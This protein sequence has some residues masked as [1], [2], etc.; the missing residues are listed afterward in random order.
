VEGYA[1][2]VVHG[3]LIATLLLD[4][5]HREL[6]LAQVKAFNFKALKP[7][8]DTAPFQVCGRRDGQQ[9][10]LWAVTPEGELAMEAQAQIA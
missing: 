7:L 1:G 10:F 5:L 3:P 9:V 4:L 8:F 2:L 6:P